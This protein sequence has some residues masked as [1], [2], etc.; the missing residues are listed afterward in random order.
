[1][2]NNAKT[3]FNNI[4]NFSKDN[5]NEIENITYNYN[6]LLK[7]SYCNK[8]LELLK[9]IYN[10][11]SKIDYKK[12]DIITTDKESIIFILFDDKYN[13]EDYI[14]I[15]IINFFIHSTSKLKNNFIII[16]LFYQEKQLKIEEDQLL[17]IIEEE[18]E[19][20]KLI[21]KKVL[22]T[23]KLDKAITTIVVHTDVRLNMHTSSFIELYSKRS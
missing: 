12:F 13:L 9:L 17:K 10:I 8:F 2:I 18:E 20:L 11:Q 14:A 6:I 23:I 19:L 16:Y 4:Y 7:Y 1:M 3:V 22:E 21:D 15:N 5:P